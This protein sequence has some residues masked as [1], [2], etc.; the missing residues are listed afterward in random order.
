VAQSVFADLA[1]HA[2]KMKPGTILTAWLYQVARRTAIDV[3]RRESRRQLREQIAVEMNTM[4]AT[5]ADWTH[6]GPLL[7]DAM[8]ALEETDR[9]AILLR[10]F[11]NKNLREVGE[12]LGTS[13]D[14]A[15]KR[16]SRA[17]ERLREFFTKRGA[18]VG[19]GGLVIIISANAV[20]AAPAG[21][22]TT[23]SA[24]AVLAGTTYAAT[25]TATT[26]K[27]IAMTTLQKTL[28]T[29]TVAMLAG[30]GI[31]EA[32]QASTLR[33]QNQLLQQQ[34]EEQIRQLQN[35]RDAATN[36]AARLL[37][38]NIRLKSE[39][40]QAQLLRLRGEIGNVRQKN[41]DLL[42]ENQALESKLAANESTNQISAYERSILLK[43]HATDA[44][45][46]LLDAIRKYAAKNDGQ[47]PEKFEQLVSSGD[48]KTTN[49]VGNLG[50]ND[51]EL[52]EAGSTNFQ[53][54][55][56]VLRLRTPIPNP[57]E[58]SIMLQG[59]INPDGATF[60]EIFGVAE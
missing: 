58:Q 37:A 27:T 2:G 28:V 57:G 4:N 14:T 40:N 47:Y 34:E 12:A 32:R 60:T 52:A 13:D 16:V 41:N 20:Q 22:A 7:D 17:V 33:G 31:Y 39:F 50:L 38:E 45:S 23:I 44:T 55:K 36:Q 53:G 25:A 43:Q 6:I 51:F 18:T 59:G 21:L 11:E 56:I 46:L 49:F 30:V 3:V 35:E 1:R 42:K 9:S 5:P 54:N 15:Q 10:Y 8:A 19:A 24:A 29:A 48:L 26:I